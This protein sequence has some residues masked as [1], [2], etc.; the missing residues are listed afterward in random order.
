MLDKPWLLV[1][2]RAMQPRVV[3]N[4]QSRPC[5]RSGDA[6]RRL[7]VRVRGQFSSR[8]TVLKGTNVKDRV[9]N[10]E[11]GLMPDLISPAAAR[12]QLLSAPRRN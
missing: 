6:V 8:S 9:M 11:D 7:K 1:Y 10:D 4:C 2:L 12:Y 5:I 3:P